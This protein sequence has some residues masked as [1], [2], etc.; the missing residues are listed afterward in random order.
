MAEPA[1]SFAGL[2]RQL[3]AGATLTQQELAEEADLSPQSVSDRQRGINRTAH[4]DT[5]LLP[6]DALGLTEPAREPS[7][8]RR[9]PA[10]GVPAGPGYAHHDA[11]RAG[12]AGTAPD[13]VAWPIA[14]PPI[15]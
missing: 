7:S 6:A 13:R 3:R 5:A 2:P 4:K 15:A 1:L 10:C 8:R 11:G 12:P 9:R 14:A